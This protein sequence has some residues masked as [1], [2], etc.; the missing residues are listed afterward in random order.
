[1]FIFSIRLLSFGYSQQEILIAPNVIGKLVLRLWLSQSILKIGFDE[2]VEF[3][4]DF[5]LLYGRGRLWQLIR[6]MS[7]FNKAYRDNFIFDYSRTVKD[8]LKRDTR[9][10][11]IFSC[12]TPSWDNS[13]RRKSFATI[14]KDSHPDIYKDWLKTVIEKFLPPSTEENLVFINAWNE[15][16]EGNH[17]EPGQK[18]G[19]AY[20]EATRRAINGH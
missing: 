16:A 9:A 10:Y 11:K 19:R 13:S 12:V 6:K 14:L 7:I 3:Q 2:A 20:L 5:Y 1:M 18:W 4:P 15:W 17:L 8:M